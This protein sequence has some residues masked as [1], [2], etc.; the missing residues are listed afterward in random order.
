[1]ASKI[2]FNQESS[3]PKHLGLTIL[4][5]IAI[6]AVNIV[7]RLAV[8]DVPGASTRASQRERINIDKGWAF[9]FGNATDPSKDFKYGL[10]PFFFAKAGYGDGPANSDFDDAAWRRVDLPHDWAVELPFDA[11]GNGNHGSKAIGHDFPENSVG[12]YRKVIDVPESDRGRRISI[13]F[14]GVYRNSVVWVN[15]HYIGTEPSGYSGFGYDITD[16]LNYGGR[17]VIAVRV[18]ATVEEGWFYEGAGIY[19][20]VWLSKTDPLHVGK[21]GTFVRPTVD[22][23]GATL[24][25]DVTVDNDAKTDGTFSLLQDVVGPDGQRVAH[26]EMTGLTVKAASDGTFHGSVK[27]TAPHLW[28]PDTPDLYHLKTTIVSE[29]RTVDTY[30]TTFGIRTITFDANSGFFL[31]GK[32]MRLKGTNNHQDHAGVG[33][34]MPDA[35]QAWR[36]NQLKGM[37]SNAYRTSHNPP[38]PELLDDADRIGMMVLD[39]HRMMG[40]TPEIRGQLERLII[41]DRN[42]PSVILWSVGNEEWAL[43]GTPLG[44]HLADEMQDIVHRLDPSR[45]TTVAASSS[46]RGVSV[47]ADVIGFNYGAQHDV[48]AF[49]QRFPEKP[50]AMTEEGSTLSTRGIYFDD[51]SKVHLNAYDR[52]G[53]PSYSLSIEEGWNHVIARPWMSGMFVWTGFDYRG[54]PTPFGWPAISSQ[55]GM[56]DTTG[57]Y[58]DSAY[59]LKS[60][61]TTAPMVHLL[62][63]WNWQGK[64]GQPIDVRV[65]SNA[66]AVEL[67]LNG[68]SLGRKTMVANS[69]LQWDVPYQAGKLEARAY[70]DGK[71]VANAI[72]STSGRAEKVA[73]TPDKHKLAADGTDVSVVWVNVEDKV[74]GIVPTASDRIKFDVTGPIRIIGVGNGDPGSHEADRTVDRYEFLPVSQWRSLAVDGTGDQTE[75]AEAVD[76]TSWRDPLQWLPPEAQPPVTAGL[77]LRGQFSRPTTQPGDKVS[78]FVADLAPSQRV[79]VNGLPVE[80]TVVDGNRQVVLDVDGLKS[81]NSLSY[82][83]PTPK[84]GV[85]SL[86]D[87]SVGGSRWGVVRINHPAGPWQRSVFN[88]WAQV[89]VQSTGVPGRAT[90]KASGEGLSAAT[91]QFDVK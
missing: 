21:W 43:E 91:A 77:V 71:L 47:S 73:L 6:G 12:W 48:D 87:V 81:E 49:H 62:P 45:R 2:K 78:L 34:A 33:T 55:F 69:H 35:L 80:T 25:I 72:V 30:D 61:W 9:A 51:R 54:E 14:D 11:R 4:S 19:R 26:A 64:E 7:P 37:G 70:S 65:Y 28:S 52:Q 67:F 66:Q 27:V 60:V 83:I 56:L 5:M 41:R 58:K 76:T 75:V 13:D 18:D 79:Y 20:H 89:I 90:L 50:A 16:Y 23:G 15:G 74:G 24:D 40:T 42:H 36:L 63:H 39:E 8:A 22:K 68:K 59:Y 3:V 88:G 10:R 1:M 86:A 53:R 85:P 84:G 46:G 17:N 82:V 31:N 44:T 29:G 32:P 38:A 57:V